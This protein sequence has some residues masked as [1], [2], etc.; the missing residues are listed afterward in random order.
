MSS[1]DGIINS[2]KGSI[3]RYFPDHNEYTDVHVLMLRWVE[4]DLDVGKEIRV[5]SQLFEQKF[6]YNVSS[7][8][9]PADGNQETELNEKLLSVDKKLAADSLLIVYY[10]GHCDSDN[11]GHSRW[12]AYESAPTP[13]RNVDDNP[14]LSWHFIQQLFFGVKYDVLL[15]LD[16][17]NAAAIATGVKNSGRFEM[18]AACAMNGRTR[19]PSRESFTHA[20]IK[21]LAPHAK[22]GISANDLA[23]QIRENKMIT[24]TPVY[25]DFARTA[26]SKILLKRISEPLAEGYTKKPAGYVLFRASLSEDPKGKEIADWLKA[27]T[28]NKVI[29]VDIEALVLQA[30]QLETFDEPPFAYGPVFGRL[31]ESAQREIFQTIRNLHTSMDMASQQATDRHYKGD[32]VLIER[33]LEN[34][35]KATGAVCDAI[36]TPILQE[37]NPSKDEIPHLEPYITAIGATG[38]INLRQAVIG[39]AVFDDGQEIRHEK[40]R[41]KGKSSREVGK[42]EDRPVILE[43]FCY[44]ENPETDFPYAETLNQVRRMSGLL[45]QAKRVSF[46]IL[47]C[48][49][50]FHDRVRHELGL[51]FEPPP[52]SDTESEL[53]TLHQLYRKHKIVPLGHRI[54][55]AHALTVAIESFHRV[56]WVHKAIRSDNILFNKMPEWESS[57]ERMEEIKN[58]R[59]TDFDLAKPCLF[60]FEYARAGDAGTNLEEDHSSENNLYRHPDRWGRPLV[61]FVKAH[62]VFALGIVMFEIALW[63]DISSHLKTEERRRNSRL[64]STEVREVVEKRCK[65][66]IP[67]KA[68]EVMA[69]I[70]LTCIDFG[71]LT[72]GMSERESQTYFQHHVTG[73]LESLVG[74]V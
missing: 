6:C 42:F 54:Y 33:Y 59:L 62:D 50:Y 29:G 49:G 20:L 74:R 64:K 23:S 46:H 13:A 34:I 66:E 69:Q 25:H 18:I 32:N 41:Y 68:G 43:M 60:G 30:R 51:V 3:G 67:H 8:Q 12:W 28:P 44:N 55:L 27:A 63:K 40:L 35:K 4:T 7:F 65:T 17:C 1:E 57:Q 10:A 48:L 45:S 9:I 39:P 11:R 52:Q 61:E 37:I 14:S 16:C 24:E 56:G 58:A 36:E 70:I 72:T 26:T 22:A 38:S 53:M 19:A 47:P 21:E 31:S 2:F 73:K 15:L 5:L 71:G